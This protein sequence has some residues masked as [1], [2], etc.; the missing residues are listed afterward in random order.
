MS[1]AYT[2][3][4]WEKKGMVAEVFLNRPEK[5]NAMNPPFWPEIRDVFEKINRDPEIRAAILAGNGKCFSAGLDLMASTS[6]F[7][8]NEASGE[9]DSA[10]HLILE[11]QESLNV[12]EECKK[13]VIAVVHGACIGGG[14]DLIAACDVRLAA[15][16]A[17]FSLREA[18]IGMI[19]DLGS[20]NRLPAIIGQGHTREMAFTGKD[21]DA[22]RALAIGLI[23]AVYP[24]RESCLAAARELAAEIA[25]AA[26]MAVQ[27]AKEVLNF[28]K[29]KSVRDGLDY[30]AARN[31]LV[32]KSADLMEAV[33]AFMQK[34]KPVFKGK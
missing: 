34:R 9:M 27:G 14:L 5:R 11:I 21:I 19:A 1:E 24:D 20:L 30:V 8:G 18:R 31:A 17:V 4:A 7:K 15:K 16:D 32:L 33:A 3:I 13:P 12:I 23:N 26:P 29:D 6:V 2:V 25:S 10:Y 28:C 22:G